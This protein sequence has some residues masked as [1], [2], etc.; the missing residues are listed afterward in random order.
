MPVKFYADS[1]FL[2]AVFT[3]NVHSPK[4]LRFTERERPVVTMNE[5]G[6][7]EVLNAL[8][9][10]PKEDALASSAR[11]EQSFG[12]VLVF[13][14]S[15][16][17]R[18]WPEAENRAR[19]LSPRLKPSALDLLHVAMASHHVASHFLSFDSNSRQR[20]LAASAGLKVWPELTRQ[21]RGRVVR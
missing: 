13:E 3:A 18:A 19:K 15:D 21:E 1:S 10:L 6:R 7:F 8:A 12:G 20:P 2:M 9:R 16:W 17:S 5:L 4:A 11:F 14:P